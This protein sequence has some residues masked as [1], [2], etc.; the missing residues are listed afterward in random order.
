MS[1]V[2]PTRCAPSL[3][4][5]EGNVR[6]FCQEVHLRGRASFVVEAHPL[7]ARLP[8]PHHVLNAL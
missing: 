2:R 1:A 6:I 8:W 5:V 3:E 7:C 4:L